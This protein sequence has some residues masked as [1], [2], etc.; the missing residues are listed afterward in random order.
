MVHERSVVMSAFSCSASNAKQLWGL[1]GVYAHQCRMHYSTFH[2]LLRLS[3]LLQCLLP[4]SFL[5]SLRPDFKSVLLE[6]LIFYKL[7]FG[8]IQQ[9]HATYKRPGQFKKVF[10]Y[11][12]FFCWSSVQFLK[13]RKINSHGQDKPMGRHCEVFLCRLYLSRGGR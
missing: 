2:P 7:F 4:P 3:D 11:S 8:V 9:N 13:A 1:P 12:L 6:L 10:H 5:C